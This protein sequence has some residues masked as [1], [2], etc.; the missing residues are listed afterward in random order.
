[1]AMQ[2][3]YDGET[4]IFEMEECTTEQLV[5]IYQVYQLDIL[6][7]SQGMQRGNVDAMRCILWLMKQQNGSDLLRLETV[8][9]DKPVKFAS[10]LIV[11]LVKEREDLLAAAEKAVKD[12]REKTPDPKE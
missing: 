1:M 4:Y 7:L 5:K 11:A 3:E 9:I 8:T 2:I 6:G 10:A 12:A